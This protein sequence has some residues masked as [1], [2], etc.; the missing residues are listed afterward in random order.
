LVFEDGS[1]SVELFL[2]VV[3]QSSNLPFVQFRQAVFLFVRFI[4]FIIGILFLPFQLFDPAKG[5][6][7]RI[8][9]FEKQLIQELYLFL[10]LLIADVDCMSFVFQLLQVLA[11]SF[12]LLQQ[13]QF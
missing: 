6:M 1:F 9:L 4:D 8:S 2:V 11:Q 7:L 3:F 12:V 10:L 13:F 5:R